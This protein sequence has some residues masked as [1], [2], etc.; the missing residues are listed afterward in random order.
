MEIV[1]VVVDGMAASHSKNGKNS[2]EILPY[3]QVCFEFPFPTANCWAT[4]SAAATLEQL[5]VM[6]MANFPPCLAKLP[7]G[8]LV[9][10]PPFPL[11]TLYFPFPPPTSFSHSLFSFTFCRSF[12]SLQYE[13]DLIIIILLIPSSSIPQK[14]KKCF[15]QR[16]SFSASPSSCQP[17][18]NRSLRSPASQPLSKQVLPPV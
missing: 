13:S 18:P 16:V 7:R 3:L 8:V 6:K 1:F 15:S 14:Q 10:I 2:R 17:S 9:I 12:I 11:R 4:N 5:S